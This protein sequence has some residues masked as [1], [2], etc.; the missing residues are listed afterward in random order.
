MIFPARTGA[1]IYEIAARR[2]GW[3][4]SCRHANTLMR[5]SFLPKRT[6]TPRFLCRKEIA[7]RCGRDS[8]TDPRTGRRFFEDFRSGNQDLKS[9]QWYAQARGRGSWGTMHVRSGGRDRE[10]RSRTMTE[11]ATRGPRPACGAITRTGAP[12]RRKV[13]PGKA[14]CPN[15]GGLSTGPRTEEG[16]RRIAE[17]Q[18]RRWQNWRNPSGAA[19]IET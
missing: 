4:P 11:K 7:N 3:H 19:T 9:C 18:R 14:R 16:R 8:V 6:F 10:E 13:V 1:V 15:H 2:P 5:F 17:A 12:C